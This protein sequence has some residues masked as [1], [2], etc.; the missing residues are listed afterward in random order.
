MKRAYLV[1]TVLVVLVPAFGLVACGES[2]STL[3]P[4]VID[5]DATTTEDGTNPI[6]DGTNPIEDGTNPQEDAVSET[7]ADA[8]PDGSNIPR[9]PAAPKAGSLVELQAPGANQAKV[10][11][12]VKLTGVVA[13]S[14]KFGVSLSG[15]VGGGCLWG[16]FVADK[17]DT[18]KPYSGQ[19]VTSYGDKAIAGEGGRP[20][21]PR[22]TD[23]IPN[24]IRPG[25]VIDLTAKVGEYAPTTCADLSP[26]KG[27]QLVDTCAFTKTGTTTPVG[28][29]T[30]PAEQL[31]NKSPDLRKW[32]NGLVRV[33]D[34]TADTATQPNEPE[35]G[36]TFGDFQLSGSGLKITNKLWG[37]FA[38]V[39][40][41]QVF[42]E[43][44]GISNLDF[45]TYSLS[46]VNCADMKA[47]SGEVCP[48]RGDAGP[49]AASETG[50][51]ADAD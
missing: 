35:A 39:A 31:L 20:T 23:L 17:N 43:I 29:E 8:R 34:V 46:P 6:E 22:G 21:C 30:V 1:G 50:S 5:N 37:G 24:D 44:A 26:S 48:T 40:K 41:G 25:D 13:T 4:R 12:G 18:F 16:V 14:R 32:L 27:P 28:P 10:G 51:E 15:N 11:D 9:C 49:D 19:L 38:T 36:R 47:T 7:P 33:A 45:C 2:N 42:S 3:P